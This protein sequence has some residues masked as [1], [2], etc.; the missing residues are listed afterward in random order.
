MNKYAWASPWG[1][2]STGPEF[3]TLPENEQAGIICH[4]MGHVVGWHSMV[5]MAWVFSLRALFQTTKYWAMCERQEFEADEYAKKTGFAGG[6]ILFLGRCAEVKVL[7]YP[8]PSERI[9][10]L[11][12]V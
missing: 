8:L 12:N 11:L 9:K 3:Y 4:E 2:I 7:G 1:G 6:L 5:R 10:R